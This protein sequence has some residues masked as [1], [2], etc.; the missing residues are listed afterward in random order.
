[1]EKCQE[2]II[3]IEQLQNKYA[4]QLSE[5]DNNNNFNLNILKEEQSSITS[6]AIDNYFKEMLNNEQKVK[7]LN[8]L[9]HITNNINDHSISANYI[10]FCS[11]L[12]KGPPSAKTNITKKQIIKEENKQTEQSY[13]VQTRPLIKENDQIYGSNLCLI[14]PKVVLSMSQD[15]ASSIDWKEGQ[16]AQSIIMK[17]QNTFLSN[18]LVNLKVKIGRLNNKNIML[19]NMIKSQEQVKNFKVLDKFIESFIEKLAINWNEIVEIILSD[20]LE[21]E[22]LE[23]NALELKKM[24]YEKLRLTTFGDVMKN[25][26]FNHHKDNLPQFNIMFESLNEVNE[27]ISKAKET[28]ASISQKYNIKYN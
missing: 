16:K 25:C 27:M 22:V 18:E 24:D 4:K 5:Y 28:E 10:N 2:K 8:D 13:Q 14:K 11:F 17:K 3:I 26:L 1:M 9:G 20:L 19:S 7:M 12:L 23:L 21:E 6:N 15:I